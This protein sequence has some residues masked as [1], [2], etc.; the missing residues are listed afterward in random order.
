MQD[1]HVL[2]TRT[3]TDMCNPLTQAP[4]TLKH[5]KQAGTKTSLRHDNFTCLCGF[6]FDHLVPYKTRHCARYQAAGSQ[7]NHFL[8]Q[9]PAAQA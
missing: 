7:Q 4:Q 3:K 9:N 6:V 2:P 8:S 5:V 1:I